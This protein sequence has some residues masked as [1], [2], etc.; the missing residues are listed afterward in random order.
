MTGLPVWTSPLHTT[1]PHPHPD[2]YF[3]SRANLRRVKE[4]SPEPS[5]HQS[6]YGRLL[7]TL[8][9]ITDLSAFWNSDIPPSLTASCDDGNFSTL[10]RTV[11]SWSSSQPLY[12]YWLWS[13]CCCLSPVSCCS[14]TNA[15]QISQWTLTW[16]DIHH[17]HLSLS[18]WWLYLYER[19]RGQK[20]TGGERG[21][22]FQMSCIV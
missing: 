20:E 5:V 17:L 4:S 14:L 6:S 19:H 8:S 22:R 9:L 13:G 10:V 12:D 1:T 3:G 7:H 21:E 18:R 11:I 2:N 16:P 15:F